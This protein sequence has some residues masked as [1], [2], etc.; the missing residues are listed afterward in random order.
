MFLDVGVGGEHHEIILVKIGDEL[1]AYAG[2]IVK[3][4]DGEHTMSSICRQICIGKN[5]AS[6]GIEIN[7]LETPT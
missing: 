3:G 7:S 1:I 6:F 4:Y 2:N 5:A